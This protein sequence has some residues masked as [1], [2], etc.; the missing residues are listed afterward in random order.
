MARTAFAVSHKHT[1]LFLHLSDLRW[2]TEDMLAARNCNKMNGCS[3]CLIV[4]S[5]FSGVENVYK[6]ILVSVD[7]QF[8][9]NSSFIQSTRTP[10][11][12]SFY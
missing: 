1:D 4:I 7:D 10:A 11:P 3:R 5:G 2:F 12:R 6:G 8:D 9:P